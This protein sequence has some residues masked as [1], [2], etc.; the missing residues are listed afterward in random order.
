MLRA[1]NGTVQTNATAADTTPVGYRP[2]RYPKTIHCYPPTKHQS[3]PD[4]SK[5]ECICARAYDTWQ[6]SRSGGQNQ[7]SEMFKPLKGGKVVF[8][9]CCILNRQ[10]EPGSWE[11][12]D[13]DIIP[14]TEY[15]KWGQ[16][17]EG[18]RYQ[19][20]K[21]IKPGFWDDKAKKWVKRQVFIPQ[22]PNVLQR[23]QRPTGVRQ[24]R[25]PCTPGINVPGCLRGICPRTRSCVPV[26]RG[27]PMP[28]RGGR[29]GGLI[30]CTPTGRPGTS[31]ECASGTCPRGGRCRPANQAAATNARR[32]RARP[33]VS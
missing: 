30:E 16:C 27:R 18:N 22:H 11:Q 29:P 5:D 17:D 20:I 4:W 19:C 24:R 14:M 6:K 3:N 31:P 10:C 26:R 8:G 9:G 2:L 15:Q 12:K 23:A 7:I 1:K 13:G 32:M 28:V 21:Q 25:I 33:R